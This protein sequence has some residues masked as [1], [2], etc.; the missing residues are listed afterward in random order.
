MTTDAFGIA[1]RS[2]EKVAAN[3][4][5]F[6]IQVIFGISNG[7]EITFFANGNKSIIQYCSDGI[8]KILNDQRM[9]IVDYEDIVHVTIIKTG[10]HL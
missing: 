5:D 8:V 10:I 4:T 2:Y 6:Y 9:D 3:N 1:R 7:S